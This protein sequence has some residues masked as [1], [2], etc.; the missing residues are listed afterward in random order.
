MKKY[1]FLILFYSANLLAQSGEMGIGAQLYLFGNKNFSSSIPGLKLHFKYG[2]SDKFSSLSN[3]SVML[4][5]KARNS[6]LYKAEFIILVQMEESVLYRFASFRFEPYIGAG[7]GYYLINHKIHGHHVSYD[8]TTDVWGE[9]ISNGF[10]ILF[11]VGVSDFFGVFVELKYVVH[12]PTVNLEL[13][14][15]Y[16]NGTTENKE[17]EKTVSFNALYLN[18]GYAFSLF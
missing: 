17:L 6:E 1:F 7:I 5:D 15:Y 4:F 9:K 14:Q 8:E 16:N 11:N 12:K 2:F 13:V 18:I 3:A 10:G